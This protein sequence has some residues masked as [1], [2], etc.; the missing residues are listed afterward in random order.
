VKIVTAASV[1]AVLDIFSDARPYPRCDEVKMVEL[2][3]NRR[4]WERGISA[5]MVRNAV[6]RRPA[7]IVNNLVKRA[8]SE[9]TGL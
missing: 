6:G 9:I 4:G 8:P 1:D 5:A 7:G 2:F 3:A